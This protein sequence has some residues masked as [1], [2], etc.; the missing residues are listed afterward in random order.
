MYIYVFTYCIL[1][2]DNHGNASLNQKKEHDLTYKFCMMYVCMYV[3]LLYSLL[4]F[5][6]PEISI[7][8]FFSKLGFLGYF[9]LRKNKSKKKK[10]TV[11][12]KKF[13]PRRANCIREQKNNKPSHDGRSC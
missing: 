9:S 5:Y 13:Q 8:G 3:Y 4:S 7:L 6:F 12:R 1:C 11:K 10:E 2:G